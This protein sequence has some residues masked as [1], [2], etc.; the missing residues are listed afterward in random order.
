LIPPFLFYALGA[1]LT[2]F[3]GLRAWH[4]GRRNADRRAL[5]APEIN[6]DPDYQAKLELD[7]E[8]GRKRHLR[9]GVLWIAMGLY[10]AYTGVGMQREIDRAT[11]EDAAES[12][13]VPSGIQLNVKPE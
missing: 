4:F 8:K 13:P 12:A 3:G 10:M 9:M 5:H 1:A 7:R 2:V 11:A 6:D